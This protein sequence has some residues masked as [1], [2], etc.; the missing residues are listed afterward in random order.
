[1]AEVNL[2]KSRTVWGGI[3]FALGRA[4]TEVGNAHP[5]M[6]WIKPLGQAL[7]AVGTML[8]AVGIRAALA[9]NGKGT[10]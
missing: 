9:T 3:I 6:G 7:E 5:E 10:K 8:G 2:V 4:I 1:M